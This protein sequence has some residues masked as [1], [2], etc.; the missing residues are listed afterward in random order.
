MASLTAVRGLEG[1]SETCDDCEEICVE[2]GGGIGVILF[3]KCD[4][5][6]IEAFEFAI[7]DVG[8]GIGVSDVRALG[9]SIIESVLRASVGTDWLFMDF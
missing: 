2:I 9:G 1:L 7:L 3:S 8:G 4:G 6:T 5:G